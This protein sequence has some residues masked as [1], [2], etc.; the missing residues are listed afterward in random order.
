MAEP[1]RASLSDFYNGNDF[2]S[3]NKNN[4]SFRFYKN[5]EIPEFFYNLDLEKYFDQ[6][7]PKAQSEDYVD[8]DIT[9]IDNGDEKL[10]I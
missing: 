8:F 4:M 6:A 1:E 9:A 3:N 5:Q 2:D 10:C 7:L